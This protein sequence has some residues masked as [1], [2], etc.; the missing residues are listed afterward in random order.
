MNIF[1]L[2]R[3]IIPVNVKNL[4][5]F[6]ICVFFRKGMIKAYDTAPAG[7]N[8]RVKS[9]QAVF[10][11]INGVYNEY[12]GEDLDRKEW[13]LIACRPNAKKI[14]PRQDPQLHNCGVYTC[15]IM[16]MLINKIDPWVL[17]EYTVQVEYCGRLSL[18][19][20]IKRNQPIL[21]NCFSD[22][23][24][25]IEN[26]KNG[27]YK[28]EM[29]FPLT[30]MFVERNR[31]PYIEE[32][33]FH[34]SKMSTKEEE[35]IARP[36]ETESYDGQSSTDES[37]ED[38]HTKLPPL[39]LPK[40]PPLPLPEPWEFHFRPPQLNDRVEWSYEETR[41]IVVVNLTDAI[42][43]HWMHKQYIGQIMERDDVTLILEGLVS[44]LVEKMSDLK[45]LMEQLLIEF[46]DTMYPNFRRWDRVEEGSVVRYKANS[47][48]VC[49][50]RVKDYV[51]YMQTLMGENPDLP[52]TYVDE[53]GVEVSFQKATD[54]VF[55]MLDVDMPLH[56]LR[57]NAAFKSEFKMKE[58]LT[59][60][61]WCM[62]NLIGEGLRTMMGPNS[63]ISP[64]K[65]IIT[66]IP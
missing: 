2:D 3:L 60:G 20:S 21:H 63:Y 62:T 44:K 56:L 17:D 59:G 57:I 8:G 40:L 27:P 23:G 19:Y 43:I 1:E 38:A 18:F 31:L 5:W 15:L 30:S 42:D 22:R 50:M 41:R 28:M 49:P 11:Y 61:G 45:Y 6:V 37:E 4:H 48:L 16:E 54:V 36:K 51:D 46:D 29:L 53:N 65:Y 26:C 33:A 35:K 7:I 14:V 66:K 64:G 12:Y 25:T 58:I 39:P 10:S 24:L 32:L 34:L 9:V 47:N 55:Y 52:F 13:K